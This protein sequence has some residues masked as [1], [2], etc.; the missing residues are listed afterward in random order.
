MKAICGSALYMKKHF[1]VILLI[2][3]N[4][5]VLTFKLFDGGKKIA[6]IKVPPITSLKGFY[7]RESRVE[8]VILWETYLF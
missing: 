2:M 8:G 4:M 3:L 1:N 5:V 6:A 7:L